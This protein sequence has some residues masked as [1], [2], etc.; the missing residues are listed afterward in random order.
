MNKNK[1]KLT[2]DR[3]ETYQ[4]IVPGV[5]DEKCLEWIDGA[6]VTV[7]SDRN[8]EPVSIL[9]TTVDQAALQGLLRHLY[10]LSLPLIS[11]IWVDRGG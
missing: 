5:L 11:V 9:T 8:D 1:K 10:S 6:T 4:I 3:P 7:E 2:L